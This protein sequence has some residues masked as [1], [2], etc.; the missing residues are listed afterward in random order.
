MRVNIKTWF[1]ILIL[2]VITLSLITTRNKYKDEIKGL[3]QTLE[4]KNKTVAYFEGEN[5]KITA[6]RD[7]YALTAHNAKKQAKNLLKDADELK[8]KI[9]NYKNLVSHLEGQLKS[10]GKDTVHLTDTII[11]DN[12]GNHIEAKKFTYDD[13]YLSLDGSIRNNIFDF[14]YSYNTSFTTTQY[15][16]REKMFK[17]K[18]LVVDFTLDNP[19]GKM[20]TAQ[21]LYITPEPDKFYETQWFSGLV[22]IGIGI[23]IAR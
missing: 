15:W 3:H 8:S 7:S 22:G 9:R 19:N 23:F 18:S 4:V 20:I 10:V 1:G 2:V 16:K 6:E 12:K 5:G 11:I 14:T 21:S 13:S 17:N